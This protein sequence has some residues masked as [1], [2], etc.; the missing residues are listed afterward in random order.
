MLFLLS[1]LESVLPNG[2]V[3]NKQNKK[4]NLMLEFFL[5]ALTNSFQ[6]ALFCFVFFVRIH[7]VKNKKIYINILFIAVCPVKAACG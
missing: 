4:K 2:R 1:W 7:A 6:N 3:E 5:T